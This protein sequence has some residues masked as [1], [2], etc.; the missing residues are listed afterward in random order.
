[1]SYITSNI[2]VICIV[3][4]V[5]CVVGLAC[6]T[7]ISKQLG[8]SSR[9]VNITQIEFERRQNAYWE[10]KRLENMGYRYF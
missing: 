6:G 10:Y 3:G 7:W 2:N 4:G 1:M 5:G 9:I 8:W